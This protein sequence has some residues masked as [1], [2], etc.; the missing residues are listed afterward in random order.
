[1]KKVYRFKG[2]NIGAKGEYRTILKMQDCKECGAGRAFSCV[3]AKEDQH[4]RS[5]VFQHYGNIVKFE[6]LEEVK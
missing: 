6:H 5:R 1:M 3:G 4:H 2:N